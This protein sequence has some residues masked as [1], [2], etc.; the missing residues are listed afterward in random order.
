MKKLTLQLLVLFFICLSASFSQA[1]VSKRQWMVGG[2]AYISPEKLINIQIKPTAYYLISNKF[3]VGA[4]INF[5][6][7]NGEN[8]YSLNSYFVPTVRYYFGK[9]R[10]QPFL[11]A[12]YGISQYLSVFNDN[13]EYNHNNFSFYG[14]GGLGLSHF[15]NNNIA[16]EAIA[17]YSNSPITIYSSW[18]FN[19]GFQIFLTPRKH[20]E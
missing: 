7:A 3:A 4:I 5:G 8:G 2:S 15:V 1:Q 20:E 12:G 14:G 6:Y 11:L 17:G 10:T 18:F 9:S 19:L 16:L 13:T